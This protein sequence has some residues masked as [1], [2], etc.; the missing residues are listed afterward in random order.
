MVALCGLDAYV[1][2]VNIPNRGQIPNLP[3]GAV[4][5]TNACFRSDSLNPVFAGL[6]PEPIY[7]LV[8]RICFEQE[9]LATAIHNRD[10]KA[11]FA[12]FVN[13]PLVTCS[14]KDAKKLFKEMCLNTKK[15]LT[16][17]NL[18]ELENI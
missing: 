14:I 18:D 16:S 11:I 5:E 1:T 7:P 6:I 8:S 9:A 12:Q 13:D 10:L 3:I 15:Y 4:V 2:N 17:Y